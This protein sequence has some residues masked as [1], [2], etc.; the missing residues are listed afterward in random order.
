MA[1]RPQ[2]ADDLR[3]ISKRLADFRACI[4]AAEGESAGWLGRGS[5]EKPIALSTCEA[6]T[7]PVVQAGAAGTADVV[8]IE[9][10]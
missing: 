3:R 6:W 4:E 7:L 10:H 8:L 1:I 9:E 2:L 5:S